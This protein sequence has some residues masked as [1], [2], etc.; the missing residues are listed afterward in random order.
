MSTDQAKLLREKREEAMSVA[1]MSVGSVVC[2]RTADGKDITDE[3]RDELLQRCRDGKHVA[4]TLEIDAYQQSKGE[5]NRNCVRIFD[6]DMEKFG[7]SGKNRPFLRDHAQDE[8]LAVAG[9][10]VDCKSTEIAP[11]SY[12]VRLTTTITA[13][14]AC[15]LALRNLLSTVSVSFR[16]KTGTVKCSACE[17][18]VFTENCYH[19]PGQRLA[20]RNVDG[21]K[22]FVGD[23]TGTIV[24]EWVYYDPEM[25]ECSTTPVPAVPTAKIDGIRAA[26][27]AAKFDL[28]DAPM[29]PTPQENQNMSKTEQEIAALEARA[30]RLDKIVALTGDERQFYDRLGRDDQTDFLGLSRKDRQDIMTPIYT[31]TLTGAKFYSTD[32][33]RMIDQAKMSDKTTETMQKSLD[34][35]RLASMRSRAETELAHLA[36]TTE[37][38]AAILS[39]IENITDPATREAALKAVKEY[40]GK[41]AVQFQRQGLGA[42]VPAVTLAAEEKIMQLADK[43]ES[44]HDCSPSEAYDHVMNSAEGQKLYAEAEAAKKQAA[45]QN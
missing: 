1:G 12:N 5:R 29:T 25:L 38:R 32:D 10:I 2:L 17:T 43:Y 11:N 16:S 34:D 6:G 9:T 8:T 20:E 19:Y 21:K 35:A 44:E 14:W 41:Q 45:R 22:Y 39:S 31:S 37:V 36:G 27:S 40:D 24:C 26:L 3:L 33:Q 4:L 28:S 7:K 30:T 23:R 42:G 18:Q 13:P 15:E